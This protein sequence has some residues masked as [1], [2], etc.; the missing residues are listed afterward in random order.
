MKGYYI[1]NGISQITRS[2]IPSVFAFGEQNFIVVD[3]LG[4]YPKYI[5]RAALILTYSPKINLVRVIDS[6][7]PSILIADGSN[8]KSYVAR[9]K[10]TCLNKKIPFHSTYEKGAYAVKIPKK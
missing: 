1:G 3:S 8:Y 9:W 7:Q 4:L 10:Q 2:K 5:E 6:L